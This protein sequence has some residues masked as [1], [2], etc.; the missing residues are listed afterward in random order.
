MPTTR[1]IPR[2]ALLA[3]LCSQAHAAAR[4]PNL[5]V[6]MA[7]DL[8]YADLNCYGG[9]RYETPHL[10]ALA[11]QGLRFTDYHSNGPVCSPTRAALLTGRYQ[12][13]AGIDGVVYADPA[14]GMRE[15]HGLQ[16]TEVTF[17]K[18]LRAA[19]YRTAL[20]GKW[21]L[22]YATPLQPRASRLRRI[23]RLR[24]RERGLP[25][26]LRPG[27]LPRLVERARNPR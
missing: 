21:H 12:Q 16:P 3:L 24:Q 17:A 13:R 9:R 11:R 7:D 8:G 14:R 4:Q 6:I 22:G 2:V 5:V 10:D 1:L 25:L 23:P 19:G 15:A 18:L 27:R 26:A 20:F